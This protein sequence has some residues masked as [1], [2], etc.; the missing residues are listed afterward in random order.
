VGGTKYVVG[1]VLI[2]ALCHGLYSFGQVDKIMVVEG[3]NVIFQ[4][5]ALQLV[6]FENHLNAH[7][8]WITEEVQFVNHKDLVDFHPLGL[9]EGFGP[10]TT[11]NYVILRYRV[12]CI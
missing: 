2:T 8:V 7:E 9:H 10:Y 3:N 4:C 6:K 12:D 11:K 1:C 5:K